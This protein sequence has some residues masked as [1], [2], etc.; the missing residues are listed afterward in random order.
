MKVLVFPEGLIEVWVQIIH[1]WILPW[2][3]L[4]I[5]LGLLLP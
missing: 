2:V 5:L 3:F 4:S 1:A